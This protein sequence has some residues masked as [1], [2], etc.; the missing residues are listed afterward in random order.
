MTSERDALREAIKEHVGNAVIFGNGERYQEEIY[1]A[2]DAILD[3]FIPPGFC[4]AP[5]E[6]TEEMIARGTAAISYD[7][8]PPPD[9]RPDIDYAE[10]V[11]REYRAMIAVRPQVKP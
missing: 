5:L 8:L 7:D 3:L 1:K 2:A 9:A 6:A 10:D 11:R 4:I